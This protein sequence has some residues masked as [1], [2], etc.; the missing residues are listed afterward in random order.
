M[1]EYATDDE[2]T[3][4]TMLTGTVLCERALMVGPGAS[5]SQPKPAPR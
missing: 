5:L 4:A 2:A 3:M 1:V